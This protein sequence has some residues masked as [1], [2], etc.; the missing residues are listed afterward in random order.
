M[1]QGEGYWM[2]SRTKNSA[3][4][5]VW[6]TVNKLITVL[7]P[8]VMRTLLIYILGIQYVGLS[9]LFTSILGV[10]SLAELGISGAMVFSMYKLAAEGDVKGISALLYFYKRC[11]IVIGIVILLIGMVLFPF[12]KFLI[13]GSYPSDINI[14]I[15]YILYLFNTVISYFLFAYKGSILIAYQRKDV[16]INIV[17]VIVMLQYSAQIVLLVT[18][19]NYYAYIGVTPILTILSNFLTSHYVDKMYPEISCQGTLSKEIKQNISRMVKGMFFQKIGGV[20]LSSVDNIVISGFL[21]L[22]ILAMYSNYYIIIL[23]LFG[24]LSIIMQSIIPSVGN[25]INTKSVKDNYKDYLKFNFIYMWIISWC[26][27]SL[28]CIYQPFI[29]LWLGDELL[30]SD[31]LM[32]LFVFYFFIHKWMDINYVYQEAVGLWW[33]NR[34]VPLVAA[35]VNLVANIY[36]VQVI[37]LAGILISTIISILLI[38]NVGYVYVLYKFYFKKSPI[39]YLTK[40][41]YYSA[42]TAIACFISYSVCNIFDERS[43]GTLLIKML[44]CIILPNLIFLVAYYR[45]KEYRSAKQFVL[46]FVSRYL[47]NRR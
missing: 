14:H 33:E 43:M 29:G 44:I 11:Y 9:S 17:S 42:V 45:L 32:I 26:T 7:V 37:G 28:L 6:G 27:V 46:S 16:Q 8:F 18:T 34:F 3:R 41:F 47:S 25:A 20:V 39:D 1:N 24:F 2:D 12:L 13:K 19:K 23:S 30:L 4:N 21:G 40:L 36:L 15:L 5:I 22:T 10:L 35:I 38:Y 31:N